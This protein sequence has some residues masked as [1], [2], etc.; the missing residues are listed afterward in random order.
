MSLFLLMLS[1]IILLIG[2]HISGFSMRQS[3]IDVDTI[4]L[5]E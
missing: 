3:A 5:D 2:I 4:R 1:I